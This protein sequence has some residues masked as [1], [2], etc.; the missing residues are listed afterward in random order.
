MNPNE[1]KQPPN[2]K[3]NKKFHPTYT[4]FSPVPENKLSATIHKFHHNRYVPIFI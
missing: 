2:H 4:G 1:L 3:E